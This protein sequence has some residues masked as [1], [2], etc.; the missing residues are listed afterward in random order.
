MG[1]FTEVNEQIAPAR[2]A[3]TV[4]AG[5]RA[6]MAV[7]RDARPVA[8]VAGELGCDW[9]TVNRAVLAWGEA[10]LA[11]DGDRVGAVR[12]LGLDETL[13][14]RAGRWCPRN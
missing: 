3:L 6:T 11:A 9:H 8:G 7:G 10:L 1:S 2:G 14:G 12:A 13:F 4:R 5:R